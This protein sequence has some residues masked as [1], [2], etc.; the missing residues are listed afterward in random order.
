[1]LQK[2]TATNRQGNALEL[3]LADISEGFIVREI[4]GL[5]PVK[6]TLVSSMF[7]HQDGA[8]HHTSYREPRNIVI[9]LGLAPTMALTVYSLRSLLYEFFMPKT[10]V[11]LR[12]TLDGGS[13]REIHGHIETA[14]PD[15]FSKEPSIKISIMCFTPEFV[16]PQ[17]QVFE[18]EGITTL[19][20]PKSPIEYD[21]TVETGVLFT[22]YVNANVTV[23]RIWQEIPGKR[24]RIVLVDPL[25]LQSGDIFQIN[26][27]PGDRYVRRIRG[28]TTTSWLHTLHYSSNWLDLHPGHNALAVNAHSVAGMP[29][30][31]T[32]HN[33]YGGL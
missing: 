8:E 30:T 31:I 3:P 1:M 2:L 7:V 20:N 17:T 15:I 5:G 6:A 28:S 10:E 18:G 19:F 27:V 21:G 33:R 12:F 14:E 23:V 9:T 4:E 16:D 13:I 26:S 11:D 32:Y 24:D 25:Q 29:Y 22:L